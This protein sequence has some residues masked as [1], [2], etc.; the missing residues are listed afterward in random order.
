[1]TTIKF[2]NVF[3]G[4]IIGTITIVTLAAS[5]WAISSFW[6]SYV[7]AE[8]LHED[9]Q[10]INITMAIETAE[11]A[12]KQGVQT[13]LQNRQ[14]WLEQRIYEL[15]KDFGGVNVPTAPTSVKKLYK[16]YRMEWEA[17]EKKLRKL[18]GS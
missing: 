3:W 17:N 4:V 8:T 2:K 14:I 16:R 12:M 6:H 15:E 18:T 9:K 7:S 11:F 1:M 10:N 5:I 13:L